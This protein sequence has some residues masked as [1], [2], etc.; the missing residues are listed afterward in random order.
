MSIDNDSPESSDTTSDS[1]NKQPGPPYERV[2]ARVVTKI[3]NEPFLFVIAIAVLVIG[4]SVLAAGVGAPELRFTILVIAA[5]AAIVIVGYYVL[6]VVQIQSKV[7]SA[8]PPGKGRSRRPAS[9]QAK[10]ERVTDVSTPASA[11]KYATNLHNAVG[12][13][14]GDHAMVDQHRDSSDQLT[15]KAHDSG[16]RMGD[17]NRTAMEQELAQHQRNLNRLK[18]KKAV[19]A[20]GEEPL[21]LLNQIDAE[22][23]EIQRL[24]AQ[25]NAS[26]AA[27]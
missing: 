14:I 9:G 22:E 18:A 6:A 24:Q 10:S 5:L 21:S 3:K 4:L 11:P 20:A 17:E 25:L 26:G 19:Y 27:N 15:P 13:A 7:R 2:L 16:D 23:R 12:V 1:T 8:V